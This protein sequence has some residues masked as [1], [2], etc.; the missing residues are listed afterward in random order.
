[1]KLAGIDDSAV[2]VVVNSHLHFDHC[3]GNHELAGVPIVVQRAE[4]EAAR[5]VPDYT[6]PDAIDFPG[7]A[8]DE[9]DGEA[10][11]AQG[12]FV[13]PT[14]GHTPGHQSVVVRCRDGTV[15]LAGQSHNQAAEF[16]YDHL[17]LR[18]RSEGQPDPLPMHPEWLPRLL[19][20]DPRR[21][22]FAHDNAVW[23]PARDPL[24]G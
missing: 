15:I 23:E 21:V 18:A 24:P 8:Y 5:T 12:V 16:T 11:V 19:Q 2:S 10:E 20:L 7:V 1:M 17:A 3:G 22:V 13:V 9:I 14:P 6:L 4:L